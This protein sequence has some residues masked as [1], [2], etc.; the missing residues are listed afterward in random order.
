MTRLMQQAAHPTTGDAN[1]WNE[2]VSVLR[3]AAREINRLTPKNDELAALA[4]AIDSADLV[5]VLDATNA[6][7]LREFLQRL[8][9]RA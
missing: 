2:I 1:R 9:K 4:V 7:I 3:A 5:D 8:I 6:Q